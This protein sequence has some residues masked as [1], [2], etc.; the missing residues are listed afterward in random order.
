MTD[1]TDRDTETEAETD[2]EP[3][4]GTDRDVVR[5]AA[6]LLLAAVSAAVLL[7]LA[8]LLPGVGRLLPA[9]PV[10]L[11]GV[12]VAV[13]TVAVVWSLLLAAPRVATLVRV[14]VDGR[15]SVAEHAAGVAYWLVVLAAVLVAHAGL[16]GLVVPALG[17]LA[18]LYDGAFLLAGLVPLAAVAARLWALVDP[19]AEAVAD[20]VAG[21]DG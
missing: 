20:A 1:D 7:A 5:T 11:L 14:T 21:S 6:R 4:T 12:A 13:V 16:A 19:A 15:A 17:G 9:L 8:S 10:S 2:P 3:T 18:W